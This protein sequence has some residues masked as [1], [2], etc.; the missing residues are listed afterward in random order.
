MQLH[1]RELGIWGTLNLCPQAVATQVWLQYKPPFIAFEVSD[2]FY[3]DSLGAERKLV[4]Q[5]QVIGLLTCP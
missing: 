3:A 2:D 5:I 1:L 4:L